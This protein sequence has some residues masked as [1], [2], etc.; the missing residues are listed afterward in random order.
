MTVFRVIASVTLLLTS[1]ACTNLY[2]IPV[3]TPLEPKLDTAG[4]QRILIAGL[5]HLSIQMTANGFTSIS[6]TPEL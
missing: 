4:F 3:E 2:E 5:T 6:R 1:F